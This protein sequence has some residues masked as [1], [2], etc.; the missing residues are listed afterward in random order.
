MRF[1]KW[2]SMLTAFAMLFAMLPA[3]VAE[4]EIVIGMEESV[5]DELEIDVE[6]DGIEGLDIIDDPSIA[7]VHDAHD[8]DG[9]EDNLLIAGEGECTK[10]SPASNASGDFEIDEYGELTRYRG[11]AK[12]VVIPDGVKGIGYRA[13]ADDAIMESVSI[14]NSVTYIGGYAFS[15]CTELKSVTIPDSVNDIGYDVFSNC[16]SLIS[17]QLPNN[18][19]TIAS[20]LFY[21][22]DS[23]GEIT[24]P[25]NIKK[26]E[27]YAFSGCDSLK[28]IILPDG[29]ADIEK[30]AFEYCEGLE[31]ITIPSSVTIIDRE[32]FS[33]SENVVIRGTTDSYAERFA[34]GIG[35]P[36]NAPVVTISEETERI[37]DEGKE[38][39]YDG[40]F[41]CINQT[42]A[43]NAIQKPAD[44]ARPLNWSSS[45]NDIVTVDQSGIIKGVSQGF[46]TISVNTA[47]DKGKAAQIMVYVPEPVK[48]ELDSDDNDEIYIGQIIEIVAYPNLFDSR[49]I[50]PIEWTTSDK[51]II[52]IENTKMDS[53]NH[54]VVVIRGLKVGKAIITAT[55]SEGL[56]ASIEIEVIRPEVESIKIDQTGP[57]TLHPGDQYSLTATLSP[58]ES[59]S[60]LTWSSDDEDIATVSNNGIVTAVGEGYTWIEVYTANDQSDSIRVNVEPLHPHPESVK[61]DQSGP[62][63][64]YPGQQCRLSAALKPSDAEAKLKWHT[65]DKRIATVSQ[66]GLVTAV[67]EGETE[68]GVETDNECEAYID[69]HVLTPPEKITL[70]KTK[71]TLAVGDTL[72]LK[73]TL[74]PA[75]AETGFT[76]SSSNPS[77]ATVSKK[78]KVTALKVG[79]AKITVKTDNGKKASCTVTVKPAPTKVKL[80]KTK[81]TLGVKEKLPLKAA[82]SPS[83]AY[84]TLTWKS[85][86][87][88]VAAVSKQG[89]VTPKKPG[90][91]IVT[92][93]THNG[94]T[95]KATI[96][97]KKAPGKV[98]LN[99]SGTVA[100]A[101]GKKLKLKAALPEGTASA[102]TW[103]SSAPKVAS[104]DQK[105]NV[106]A[107]KKG[108]AVITVETFNGKTAK[109]TISVK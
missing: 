98:T 63:N 86:D 47:D 75:D 61:I 8:L 24:L 44:L 30:G 31:S 13:F 9:L 77:V 36:F 42:R 60:T 14:P 28:S 76:W 81:A 106:K 39:I 80:N 51:T 97:V 68:I 16:E 56:K 52:A 73:K 32:A 91:A 59:E 79:T 38:E 58:V 45:N 104:V 102:L 107:L 3:T 62:I 109:V 65:E 11:F 67:R 94:K 92:V 37:Y 7:L 89:V 90:T 54:H 101:V 108:T 15:G 78:G 95:A 5:D 100:L 17:I 4:D 83:S 22:C 10:V 66:D 35:I 34:K 6:G 70:S 18:L 12:N 84:T 72:T 71:A 85:S 20:S 49:G 23:L 48:I 29:V 53:C 27:A 74:A 88:A 1:M 25:A 96:T 55:T 93:T 41:L 46:A 99:K 43:L 82:V 2:I 105:G 40:L 64:L 69:I 57:I 87:K 103:T 21:R 19:T 50:I 33:G 26:I